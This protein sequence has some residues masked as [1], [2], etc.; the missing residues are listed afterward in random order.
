MKLEKTLARGIAGWLQYEHACHRSSIFSEKYL[1]VPIAQI[2][3]TIYGNK[4][5]AEIKHP[6]LGDLSP[7]RGRPP[8]LDFVVFDASQKIEVA[9]ETKWVGK[10]STKQNVE[11]IIWDLVRLAMIGNNTEMNCYFVL[12]GKKKDLSKLFQN[13]HFNGEV[14]K[15]GRIRPIYGLFQK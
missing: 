6:I 12:A 4:V 7:G 2:L 15:R 1:S 3:N 5:H 10:S 9:I 8:E 14:D 13:K 11:R